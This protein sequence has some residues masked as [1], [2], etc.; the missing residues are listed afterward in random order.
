M[1]KEDEPAVTTQ[2]VTASFEFAVPSPS[3]NHTFQVLPG[4]ALYFVGANG[5]GKSRLAVTIEEVLGE[6]CHRISAHRALS[7]N[8]GVA[9]ISENFA[10]LGLRYGHAKANGSVAYRAGSRWGSKAATQLLNDYD[11]LVQVLYAEQANT[12]L[13]THKT[14]RSGNPAPATPTKFEK[15]EEIWQRVL[16]NRKLIITGDDIQASVPGSTSGYSAAEMSDGERA[17]FY[18]VGQTLNAPNDSI[19]LFDEPELHIHR[20]ILSRLWDELEAARPDCV[21]RDSILPKEDRPHPQEDRLKQ[22]GGRG[23]TGCGLRYEDSRT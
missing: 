17:V 3:G 7:L 11:F 14:V 12:A 5:G 19:I 2:V 10:L 6:K 1:T 18:L 23:I 8:P 15:L 20:A 13:A 16:P 4:T 9:K 21:E 22:C